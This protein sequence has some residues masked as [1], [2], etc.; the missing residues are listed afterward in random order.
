[1]SDRTPQWG[2]VRLDGLRGGEQITRNLTMAMTGDKI[3]HAILI[4]GSPGTGKTTLAHA[5]A[6]AAMCSSPVRGSPCGVCTACKMIIQGTAPELTYI[7][8][9]DKGLI[10]VNIVRRAIEAMQLKPAYAARK[11]VIVDDCDAMNAQAQN[12][13]LK[14][15]E[16]P[17][18]TGMLILTTSHPDTLLPTVISRVSRFDIDRASEEETISYI[19]SEHPA[20]YAQAHFLHTY[21]GGAT[22]QIDRIC[23]DPG[24]MELRDTCLS[25]FTAMVSDGPDAAFLFAEW[26]EREQ[27]KEDHI[28]HMLMTFYSDLLMLQVGFVDRVANRDYQAKLSPLLEFVDADK[29][30]KGTA[31]IDEY[32]RRRR[33]MVNISLCCGALGVALTVAKGT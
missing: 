22:G 13:F 25:H 19:A 33:A 4:V 11:V 23:A 2:K 32:R 6:N 1:M 18:A 10:P 31:A 3:P 26:L 16:E 7:A 12:A 9:D 30:L 27:D 5:I 8:P 17:P 15:L 28:L 14:T 21:T 20:Y 29:C 24:F